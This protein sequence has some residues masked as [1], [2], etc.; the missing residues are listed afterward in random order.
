[1]KSV[2]A[3]VEIV[4]RFDK[5]GAIHVGHEAEGHRAVAIVAQ[6]FVGHHRAQVGAADAD[7]DD[8]ADALAGVA[9]PCAA[10]NAIGKI[11]HLVEHGVD[12]RHHVL[13]VHANGFASRR[14]QRHMQNRPLLRDVDL[15]AVKH[16]FDARLQ[17]GL[18][19]QVDE[20]L[21]GLGR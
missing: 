7:V 15:L 12:L 5:I 16:G 21:D 17:S 19:G 4:Y 1:M 20:Q 2:S 3:G 8:V 18:L 10:A 14:A 9:L 13:A 6:R 11:C